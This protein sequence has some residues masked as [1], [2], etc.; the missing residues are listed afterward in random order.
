MKQAAEIGRRYADNEVD[1]LR[2]QLQETEA[3]HAARVEELLRRNSG[4]PPGHAPPLSS[5]VGQQSMMD[6]MM[7]VSPMEDAT[8]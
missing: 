1:R 7:K 6:T 2:K 3:R 8:A 4:P 5:P